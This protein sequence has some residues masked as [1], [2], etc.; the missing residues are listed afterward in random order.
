MIGL[1]WPHLQLAVQRVLELRVDSRLPLCSMCKAEV[2]QVTFSGGWESLG[3]RSH[4]Q[5]VHRWWQR[6]MR[7]VTSKVTSAPGSWP[8]NS[9]SKRFNALFWPPHLL[10]HI[11]INVNINTQTK[12]GWKISKK[13]LGKWW[14]AGRGSV[15]CKIPLNGQQG[16]DWACDE[17]HRASP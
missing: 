4:S 14:E 15:G 11:H 5:G 17:N 8:V 1:R 3:D 13:L 10:T 7:G 9:S 2:I 12:G 6:P 16:V